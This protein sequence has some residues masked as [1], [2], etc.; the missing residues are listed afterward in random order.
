MPTL[1]NAPPNF[2]VE[3]LFDYTILPRISNIINSQFMKLLIV[4]ILR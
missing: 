4:P 1:I 3:K 2:L